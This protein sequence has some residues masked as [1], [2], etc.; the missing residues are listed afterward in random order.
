MAG[1]QWTEPIAARQWRW[2]TQELPAVKQVFWLYPKWAL[3]I[4]V[5]TLIFVHHL[6]PEEVAHVATCLFGFAGLL[7]AYLGLSTWIACKEG[8]RYS[9]MG[10]GLRVA[11]GG[12]VIHPWKDIENYQIVK[13]PHLPDLRVL[14]FKMKRSRKTYQWA[15]SPSQMDERELEKVMQ[16]HL[17]QRLFV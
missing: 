11:Y 15:F 9:I 10:E 5:P 14:E 1:L 2:Q 12:K 16:K 13:H 7:P 17:C 4:G 6:A 3:V 8:K